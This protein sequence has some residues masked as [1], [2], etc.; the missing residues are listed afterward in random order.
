VN[1]TRPDRSRCCRRTLRTCRGDALLVLELQGPSSVA[2]RSRVPM[3]GRPSRPRVDQHDE[4]WGATEAF[5]GAKPH[6]KRPNGSP[7]R[8]QNGSAKPCTAVQFRSPPHV[9]GWSDTMFRPALNYWLRVLAPPA[10]RTRRHALGL[11]PWTVQEVGAPALQRWI[12]SAMSFWAPG[13]MDGG[14]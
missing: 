7:D 3:T 2:T 9:E 1:P 12:A 13:S 5:R 10:G 14:R 4:I 6:V 11:R 8:A